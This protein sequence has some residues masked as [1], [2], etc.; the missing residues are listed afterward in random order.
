MFEVVVELTQTLLLLYI[1]FG[2][3][4]GGI[5]AP[6]PANPP[7]SIHDVLGETGQEA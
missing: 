6:P 7:E 4:G 2:K 1:V 3:S 5:K